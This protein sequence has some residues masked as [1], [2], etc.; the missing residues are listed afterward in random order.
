MGWF[1][2]FFT[3]T[4]QERARSERYPGP[5]DEDHWERTGQHGPDWAAASSAFAGSTRGGYDFP[6]AGF[7]GGWSAHYGPGWI[8]DE[9]RYDQRGF[10]GA[11]GPTWGS[12]GGGGWYQ[13]DTSRERGSG[14]RRYGPYE[15]QAPAGLHWRSGFSESSID[16]RSRPEPSIGYGVADLYAPIRQPYGGRTW[17][18]ES[19]GGYSVGESIYGRSVVLP[20]ADHR[21]RGPRAWRRSDERLREHVSDALMEHPA[22][23]ASELEV[24]VEQG[25]VILRG[26]VDERRKKY[27][28]EDLVESIGGVVEV[29][30]QIRV[31]RR[32]GRREQEP[33]SL[34]ESTVTT[35][36]IERG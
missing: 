5:R 6:L 16:D 24:E 9:G 23:D 17:T 36:R 8:A 19:Q 2:E 31:V 15:M 4:G 28:V 21:G 7:R 14:E 10:T 12:E 35:A 3:G 11:G 18:T 1:R 32:E 27:A 22:I 20:D 13:G 33:Y 34:A 29:D 30:N 25:R 26:Q